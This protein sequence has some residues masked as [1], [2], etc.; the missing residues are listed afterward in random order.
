MYDLE[1]IQI[2]PQSPDS[3]AGQNQSVNPVENKSFDYFLI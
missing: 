3:I 1:S 2:N